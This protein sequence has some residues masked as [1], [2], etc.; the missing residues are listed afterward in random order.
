MFDSYE[1]MSL[2]LAVTVRENKAREAAFNNE[3]SE[4]ERSVGDA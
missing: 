4:G 1:R 2:S 3:R